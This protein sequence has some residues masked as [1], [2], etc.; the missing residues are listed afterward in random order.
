MIEMKYAILYNPGHNRVYYETSL[1]LSAAELQIVSQKISVEIKNIQQKNMYGIDYLIFETDY[2]LSQTDIKIVSD[3]SFIYALFE[4][5][6]INGQIYL[7][8]I[9]KTKE[10][11]VDESISTILKY[12]GKTN[13]IFTRMMINVAVYSQDNDQ[14]IRLLDPVAGKGTTLYEGLVKG[15][16]VYGIEIS[17]HVVNESYHFIK[18]FLETA[19]YKFHC[20]SI[21]ISG[22][23]K[24]F[25]ALRHTFE[26]AKTKENWK[27]KD[28]K[29]MELVAG[30]SRYA[31]QYYKKNFFDII[32]GDLPYGVQ[33][34]NVT[35]Q[36][37][38][39][40]TRNP[41]ELL[42]ICLP[43]W[44][45]VLKPGGIIV[46]AW[47]CNVLSRQKMEQLLQKYG[48]TVKNDSLYLQF[49]H[50]VDQAILRD[51]IVARKD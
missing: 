36:K 6:D 8:P 37:Q 18:R 14:D 49:E 24:S 28:T 11:F 4:I 5:E 41:S 47:N 33:H 45:K 31:D 9:L 21:K 46:L 27:R 39:S 22:P 34:G 38:S 19:R 23:N 48:L 2:A 29:I 40:F 30:D 17:D 26:I 12:T 7:K 20:D 35:N 1:K 16:H 15:H 10:A 51:I 3:L 43:S 50:R 25:S 44:F 32:V 13:E 42:N